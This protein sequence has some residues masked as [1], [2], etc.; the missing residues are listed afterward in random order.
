MLSENYISLDDL[1][2]SYRKAKQEAFFDSFHPHS[3]AF[4]DFEKNL[5]KNLHKLYTKL[6]DQ[7][8]CWWSESEFIGGFLYVPKSI[9]DSK[10]K[11]NKAIHYRSVDP[12]IDWSQRFKENKNLKLE[13]E[14]RLIISPTVEYQIISAL[15]IIKVGEKL[16]RKLDD[17]YAYGNRLRRYGDQVLSDDDNYVLNKESIGLFKPYFS[18]Y[19]KWRENGLNIMKSMLSDGKPVTAMTMDLSSFYHRINPKFILRT[20]FLKKIGAKLTSYDKRFTK[21]L[22]NSIEAWYQSTPDYSTSH[23]NAIPVGLSASKIISNVLLYELDKEIIE[24]IHPQYYGRYVDDIFLV[25]E[26]AQEMSGGDSILSYIS[27]RIDF[28]KLRKVKGKTP[29]LSI[30]LNYAKDSKL[31]FSPDKQKI[32]SLSSEYGLDL[33]NQICSQIRIQS[34]EYRMLPSIPRNSVQMAEKALLASPDASLIADAL[35]KADA[36]SIRR[37]GLSLLLRDI[38]SYSKDLNRSEWENIRHEFYGLTN[39][40]LLTP[41]GFFEYFIYYSRIFQ[42]MISNHDF[43]SAKEFIFKL[44]ETIELIMRTTFLSSHSKLNICRDYFSKS[45]CE[46][47]IKASTSRGFS[48]WDDLASIIDT[49]YMVFPNEEVNIILT[50]DLEKRSRELLLSDLGLRPYKDYWYYGQRDDAEC[51]ELPENSRTR[52][53]LRLHLIEKFRSRID[54]K[55]PY[56]T[57]LA[58]PT[59]PMSI[60]EIVLICPDTLYDPD[61]FRDSIMGLRGA[62]LINN[63]D[64]VLTTNGTQTIKIPYGRNDKVHV[65]LTSFETSDEIY[66]SALKGTPNRSLERYERVN[67][68]INNILSSSRKS[69]YIV[70]PECSLPYK[71]AINIAWKLGRQNISLIA[72]VEYYRK[73]GDDRLRNDCLVSLATMWPGYSSNFILIQPKFKPSHE[74]HKKLKENGQS[75]YV[76]S[77]ISEEPL[78]YQHGDFFFGVLICSDLT[79]PNNRVKF[80]GKIDALFLL[81]WNMDVNT[82]S[83]LVEGAAHD[84]HAFIVQVNN[85]Q[86]GDSRIRTPYRKPH[87]RDAVRLKGGVED[88]Y[89]IAEIDYLPL[90][91]YQVNGDFTSNESKFKPVPIGFKPSQDRH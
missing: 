85:R 84:I 47:A 74:E 21:L 37:L 56:W 46:I 88:Y 83:Y 14:Y 13:P 29:C 40:Y 48:D 75:L 7:H 91:N 71:W 32:F 61:L 26:T 49:I 42:I 60:Q 38:E 65:A 76:P 67:T 62:R 3:L 16:E 36:V 80:Q 34:S 18:A 4:A 86:Y 87:E 50:V 30:N 68:I 58:F 73:N 52:H 66:Y 55:L 51:I 54:L 2:L 43:N 19:K 33:I 89:V 25:M 78:I 17:R 15:W 70:F 12:S 59:R 82:F 57:A 44:K 63:S 27:Q 20:E 8:S 81:E 22:I 90:R 1:Y 24:K 64:L 35:R 77:V 5:N 45:L 39:R 23:K 31:I 41:K 69:D 53:L 11:K 28:I 10:W 72:G 9:D 6:I 79:D